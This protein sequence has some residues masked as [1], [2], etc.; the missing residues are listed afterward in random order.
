VEKFEF[1]RAKL[2]DRERRS[3]LLVTQKQPFRRRKV[4]N[5]LERF[6][7]EFVELVKAQI[8]SQAME[9]LIRIA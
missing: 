1:A 2:A 6:D 5:P 3:L 7:S 4:P 8:A 9:S